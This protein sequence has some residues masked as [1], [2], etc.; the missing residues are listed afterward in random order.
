MNKVKNRRN[1]GKQYI[2]AVI[3]LIVCMLHLM[4]V[5]TTAQVVPRD[6]T[7]I[8]AYI[9]DHKKQ[10]SLLLARSTLEESN[11]LLHEACKVTHKAYKDV[12]VELDKYTRAFDVI[13]LVYSTVSTGFNVYRTYD[14]V[15]EKIGK[16][17]TMLSD[18]NDKIVSRG[19]IESADTLL[20]AVNV[21]AVKNLAKEC[22]NLYSS[23]AVL[24]AY[25]SG[26][27]CCTTA[28][29]MLMVENIN[30]SL[31]R[32]KDIVNTAYYQTWKFIRA[33]T[34]YWKAELYRSKTIKQ[35]AD[36]AI[37]RWMQAGRLGY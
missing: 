19:R 1:T 2:R 14:N 22:E 9:N 26:K 12:N 31:D 20:L 32:I 8:E 35:V 21:R 3:L 17:K 15:S 36:E 16:Y 30:K 24:A 4:P 5:K 34:S 29:M 28:T 27:V 11:K 10:R 6:P 37:G 13:D 18:Y 23:V 25:A 7:T 33:R